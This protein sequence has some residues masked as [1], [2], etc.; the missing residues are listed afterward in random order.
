MKR[1]KALPLVVFT[2]VISTTGMEVVRFTLISKT[3]SVFHSSIPHTT[4]LQRHNA[5]ESSIEVQLPI[6][7]LTLGEFW[8]FGTRF[9]RTHTSCKMQLR[10]KRV[11]SSGNMKP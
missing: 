4:L 9:K 2:Y 7:G 6:N 11:K 8:L 1:S 3:V 5:I 10:R